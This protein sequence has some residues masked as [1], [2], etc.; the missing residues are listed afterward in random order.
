MHAS[1]TDL[2]SFLLDTGLASKK[3]VLEAEEEAGRLGQDIERILVSRGLIGENDLR[4]ARAYVSGIPFVELSDAIFD[5]AVLSHIPEPI[6]REHGAVAYKRTG[7]VLE[8]AFLDLAAVPEVKFVESERGVAIAPRLTDDASLKQALVA[9]RDALRREY[10]NAIEKDVRDLREMKKA[11]ADLDDA[12]VR[13]HADDP[14]T[15]RVLEAVLAHA[16]LSGAANIHIEPTETGVRVRYRLGGAMHDAIILPKHAAG[17]L[18]LR[19]KHLAG[20]DPRSTLPQDGKFSLEHAAGRFSLRLHT[21]PTAHGEKLTMRALSESA[22]GFTLESLGLEGR[23]LEALEKALHKKEGLILAS[24]PGESGKSTFLYTALDIV[25]GPEKSAASV[26]DPVEYAMRGVS[27]TQ[28][29]AGRG[30][31][32]SRALRAAATQDADILMSSDIPDLESA[33]IAAAAALSG[34]LVLAGVNAESAADAVVR[35]GDLGLDKKLFASAFLAAVGMRVVRRLGPEREKY[36]LT[37]D[38][39]KSLGQ[40]VSLERLLERMKE[41]GIVARDAVWEKIPFY[42]PRKG[43]IEKLA[44]QGRIGLYEVIPATARLRELI[45]QG[46]GRSSLVEEARAAGQTSL[47]EDGIMKAVAGLTTI[48]EVLRAAV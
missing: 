32:F 39:L 9:Y 17:R 38:E 35:I 10:G 42:K 46:A 11:P 25:N 33:R 23:A 29:D 44:Y 43:Q 3:A 36:L 18:A 22:A 40:L 47:L 27:Q 4:R 41:E 7:N 1:D 8:V 28:V 15:A 16:R 19:A 48:E 34:E 26:E 24:G 20:L 2:V 31:S 12:E 13:A 45:A 21:A 30:L 6:A 5:L 37:K 14:R